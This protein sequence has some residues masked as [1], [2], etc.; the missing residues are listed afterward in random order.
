MQR[1][2]PE[3][4]RLNIQH[5]GNIRSHNKVSVMLTNF[6]CYFQILFKRRR[7]DMIAR[8]KLKLKENVGENVGIPAARLTVM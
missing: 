6:I 1:H 8:K 2:T 7:T 4:C 5:H 3:H